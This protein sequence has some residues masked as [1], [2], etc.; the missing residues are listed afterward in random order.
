MMFLKE[1]RD[2]SIKER[3]CANG[4]K[5]RETAT[6]GDVASPTVSVESVMI[7]AA[8]EA[9]EGCDVAVVD[10]PR[11]FLS[12]D[13]NEGVLMTLGGATGRV[14]GEDRDEHIPKI[15][16]LGFQQSASSICTTTKVTI[17]MLAKRPAILQ[18]S[19]QG[20]EENVFQA[21]QIRSM[22]S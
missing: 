18:K 12:A 6:P 17:W 2:G 14:N 19:H 21:E 5:Q 7:T 10:V 13:M 3:A 11:A 9:H 16:H 8:V 22:P 4:R 15:H 20:P 1:K